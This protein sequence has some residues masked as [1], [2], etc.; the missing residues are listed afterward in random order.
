[1]LNP[2]EDYRQ[3][4]LDA[5]LI[6]GGTADAMEGIMAFQQKRKTEFKGK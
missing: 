2:G 4:I 5:N 3:R 1:M 6:A